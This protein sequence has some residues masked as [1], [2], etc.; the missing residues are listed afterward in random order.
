MS[1]LFIS[2]GK[3]AG[4]IATEASWIWLR[5]VGPKLLRLGVDPG[6]LLMGL[7]RTRAQA[8]APRAS[9]INASNI[10]IPA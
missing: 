5:N 3:S 8:A 7:L 10:A 4:H 2:I 6:K 1:E 9:S